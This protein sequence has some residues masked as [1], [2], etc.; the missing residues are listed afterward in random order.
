MRGSQG[1]R[2]NLSGPASQP[3]AASL[4]LCQRG[5]QSS[6]GRWGLGRQ[7]RAGQVCSRCESPPVHIYFPLQCW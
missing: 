6:G 2:P 3:R 7:C 4:L 5:F 1:V